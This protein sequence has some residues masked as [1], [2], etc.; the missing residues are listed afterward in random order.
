MAHKRRAGRY[1]PF[2][3]LHMY[4]KFSTIETMAQLVGGC[5]F[6]KIQIL[7]DQELGSGSYGMVCK[8]LCDE[9]L[10]AAKLLHPVLVS[11]RNIQKFHQECQLL[12]ALTH[13]NIIQYL[14]THTLNEVPTCQVLLMELM[15]ES[16][17]SLL[18]RSTSPLPFHT[19]VNLCRDI[20]LALAYL[21]SNDIIHRD[22]SSNNVL[23]TGNMRAKVTDFDMSRLADDLSTLTQ[24][25]GCAVYMS[26]EALAHT[27]KYSQKL[28]IFSFGVLIIQILTRKF[29]SPGSPRK[30]M[31]NQG[32]PLPIEV[33]VI[34]TERRKAHI[35][36]IDPTHPL[37]RHACACLSYEDKDR[38]TA[39]E[40]CHHVSELV[41]C[42]HYLSTKHDS[43]GVLVRLQRQ[44]KD[45]E[46]ELAKKDEFVS[47]KDEEIVKM[48]EDLAKMNRDIVKKNQVISKKD[49]EIVNKDE[50]IV[51]M[52][53]ERTKMSEDFTEMREEFARKSELISKKDREILKMSE[54]IARM[55]ELISR[56]DREIVKMNEELVRRNDVISR[57]DQEIVMVISRKDQEMA[58]MSEELVRKG[59]LI[60]KKDQ[61]VVKMSELLQEKDKELTKQEQDFDKKEKQLKTL[62][63]ELRASLEQF[64]D[65]I[66]KKDNDFEILT[67]KV[68]YFA[69]TVLGSVERTFSVWFG[70]ERDVIEKGEYKIECNRS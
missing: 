44:L 33:P 66:T 52:S 68:A 11:E 62:E 43:E 54:E 21:H 31:V 8:A 15:E 42:D 23:L 49:R 57:K 22:L 50:L 26:P 27:P 24:A 4:F 46:E 63:M 53:E 12:A 2:S 34:E 70:D 9:L 7:K 58:K 61:E 65:K 5:H 45:K 20:S 3:L 25:S 19:E 60:S 40:M 17:T 67:A 69:V 28:D 32:H 35:D 1:F 29:P 41:K 10:C 59:E 14:G 6:K 55:S 48:S 37:L 64:K 51:E 18:E 47:K 30:K 56:K 13:P 38:P 39:Q 36:L 16:L